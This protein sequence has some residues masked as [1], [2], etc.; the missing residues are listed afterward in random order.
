VKIAKFPIDAFYS[1]LK[2]SVNQGLPIPPPCLFPE[3]HIKE[4]FFLIVN[5]LQAT[6][7]QTG[8]QSI[9]VFKPVF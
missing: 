1:Q 8:M 4:T 3:Y 7:S 9:T 6:Q 5:L 2:P